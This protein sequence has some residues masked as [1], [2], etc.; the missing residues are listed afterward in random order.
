MRDVH[1]H[2]SGTQKA[3]AIFISIRKLSWRQGGPLEPR[4]YVKEPEIR[5]GAVRKER[6]VSVSRQPK[7]REKGKN[8]TACETGARALR[9]FRKVREHDAMSAAEM[10]APQI[11]ACGGF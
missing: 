11:D 1:K 7:G 3:G 4:Q 10:A 2:V 8:P 6:R 9:C 5:Q